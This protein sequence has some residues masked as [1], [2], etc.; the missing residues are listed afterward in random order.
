MKRK[1]LLLSL[2]P[3]AAIAALLV[4][5]IAG[6][7][8]ADSP[9]SASESFSVL[10]PASAKS[11]EELPQAAQVWLSMIE[12]EHI[13]NA[14]VSEVGVSEQP[15][16]Q[17]IVASAGEYVCF[18]AVEGGASNCGTTDRVAHGR[19][20]TATPNGCD[21]YAVVG[22]LPDGV[23]ALAV[24]SEDK[25]GTV[26]VADN[27]FT[28]DLPAVDSALVDGGQIRVDLPLGWYA[29]DNSC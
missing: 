27:V 6:T 19:I 29:K 25:G 7:S 20:F 18:Y 4:A 15:G 26:S 12:G 5:L 17:V 22:V 10:E 9:A 21:S 2:V 3:V 24:E 8:G 11:T 1:K 13:A 16:G 28:A 14:A 23:H